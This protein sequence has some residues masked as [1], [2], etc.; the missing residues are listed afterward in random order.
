M[1][2]TLELTA[3]DGHAFGA[4]RADPAGDAA[5]APGRAW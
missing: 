4:Y 1:G 3:S 5:L 2:Q